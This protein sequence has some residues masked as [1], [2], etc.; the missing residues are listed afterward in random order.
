MYVKFVIDNVLLVAEDC[1]ST[2]EPSD[3][4]SCKFFLMKAPIRYAVL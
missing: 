3:S 1:T 4:Y 2:L